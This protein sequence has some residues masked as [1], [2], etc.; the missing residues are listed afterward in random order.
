MSVSSVPESQIL[1]RDA[2]ESSM[3][4]ERLFVARLWSPM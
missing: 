1:E 2:V 4:F 3:S